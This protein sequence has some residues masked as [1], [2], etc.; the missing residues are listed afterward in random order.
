MDND[1]GGIE[2]LVKQQL[3]TSKPN[4]QGK[5]F[6][7]P[8]THSYPLSNMPPKSRVLPKFSGTKP[9]SKLSGQEPH[10]GSPKVSLTSKGN[11]TRVTKRPDDHRETVVIGSRLATAPGPGYNLGLRPGLAPQVDEAIF[12]GRSSELD[13]LSEWLAPQASSQVV[14]AVSGLGG[15]GKT[16]LSLKFAR[17]Y[18]QNY[19]AIFWLSAIS[20]GS[21]RRGLLDL[22]SQMFDTGGLEGEPEQDAEDRA[23]N[24]IR[25]WLSEP[26]NYRW[27]LIADNYDDPDFGSGSSSNGFDIR[28]Y[29]PYV[30]QGSILIT[31]RSRNITFARQMSL[32]KFLDVRESLAILE[33]RS[34]KNLSEGISFLFCID[35]RDSWLNGF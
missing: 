31:T 4:E 2:T 21:M 33:V 13:Q 32:Q 30:S 3:R 8:S 1:G 12:V 16:Q 26:A 19:S 17:C 9:I 27:L 25:K 14:V 7:G 5:R 28:K 18:R 34:G 6:F 23:I 11:S 24:R 10:A 35:T 22:A 29:F 15:M 20:E